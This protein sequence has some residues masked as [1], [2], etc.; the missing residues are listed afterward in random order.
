MSSIQNDS[1]QVGVLHP[2]SI[3]KNQQ[4]WLEHCSPIFV[5][6]T[7]DVA[8]NPLLAVFF[9]FCDEKK[10]CTVSHI[11]RGESSFSTCCETEENCCA[12]FVYRTFNYYKYGRTVDIKTFVFRGVNFN[13]DRDGRICG[14]PWTSIQTEHG[15]GMQTWASGDNGDCLHVSFYH[16]YEFNVEYDSW[17]K[18]SEHR[19]V[20]YCNTPNHLIASFEAD[21]DLPKMF[22]G[23]YSVFSGDAEQAEQFAFELNVRCQGCCCS[24]MRAQREIKN[25]LD[26]DT[27]VYAINILPSLNRELERGTEC[28]EFTPQ[29]RVFLVIFLF[30]VAA[31]LFV[32]L[33]R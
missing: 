4:R 21:P 3:S 8:I 25:N 27:N 22:H 14:K 30:L 15:S 20:I 18:V 10:T 16:H 6:A 32:F 1:K 28:F 29:R 31:F 33:V 17:L 23:Q 2:L 26:D 13:F 19:P 7:I 5:Q 11:Y 9:Y 12:S 24:P